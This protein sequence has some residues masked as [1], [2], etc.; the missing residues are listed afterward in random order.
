MNLGDQL[1]MLVVLAFRSL[2]AHQVKS[3][4][5]GFILVGGTFLVVLFGALLSSIEG[6]MSRSITSSM[7]GHYQVYDANAE[8]E[9]AL[10]P[11]FSFGSVDIG[12]IPDFAKVEKSLLQVDN[13]RA[14]VPMGITIGTVFGANE[15]DHVLESLR[16]AVRDGR[17][18][19]VKVLGE[20]VRVIAQSIYG[21]MEARAAIS[22]D[23]EKVARQRDALNLVLSEKFWDDFETDPLTALDF[24][25]ANV[26]PLAADGRL[27]YLRMIG[28]DPQQ[29]KKEFEG[30]YLVDGEMIPEGQRGLLLSKRTYEKLIKNLC[31]RDFDDVYHDVK[32]GT[33]LSEDTL[34]QEKVRRISRQYQR[35]LFQLTPEDSAEVATKLR[36]FRKTQNVPETEPDDIAAMV[37]WLLLVNDENIDENYKF[38]YDVIAPKMNLYEVPVGQEVILRGFTQSGYIKSVKVKVWGTYEFSGLESSDLA[39]AANVMDLVTWRELYGRM[40]DDQKAELDSIRETVGVQDV[41]REDAEAALFGGGGELEVAAVPDAPVFDE[42]AGANL[43]RGEEE[44]ALN[45]FDPATLHQG[46]ALNAAIILKDPSGE[47]KALTDLKAQIE[48]DQ[49]GLQVVDWQKA[50]GIV[51]GFLMTMRG[52]LYIAIFVIFLVALVIINNLMVMATLER[53][54]EIGTMRAIGAQR[55]FVMGMFILEMLVL[56]LVSG[57]IGSIAAAA[58][59]LWLGSTGIP[60]PADIAVIFF[61]GDR[62]YPVISAMDVIF[63]IGLIVFVSVLST[64][65]PAFVAARVAPVVAMQGKE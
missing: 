11:G 4:I 63:G 45:S 52:V 54:P 30:F 42:F 65:Y 19:D 43:K 49:L 21:D 64:L 12:E 26:A 27:L 16:N 22:S 29:F 15:I 34:L 35:I 56:G 3:A 33:K 61:G 32:L 1:R 6:S 13:V 57:V 7:S 28:T 58:V 2:W 9:L 24:L 25:D 40:S 62:L 23:P 55:W 17:S 46:L 39:G 53:T 38:F 18:D 47:A 50:S 44:A 59:V 37:Q 14:V 41:S 48:K 31:A 10:F 5:I 20:R 36:E 8:D 51:G 60:A